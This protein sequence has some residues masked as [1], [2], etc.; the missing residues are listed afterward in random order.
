MERM[1]DGYSVIGADVMSDLGYLIC[2][3]LSSRSSPVTNLI[4]KFSRKNLFSL[5]P[6]MYNCTINLTRTHALG[7]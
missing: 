2:S 6:F 4:E 5:L 7:M 3:R 1:L